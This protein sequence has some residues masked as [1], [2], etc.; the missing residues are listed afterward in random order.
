MKR[1]RG[2]RLTVTTAAFLAVIALFAVACSSDGQPT[3]E[4]AA[5][6]SRDVPRDWQPADI[7]ESQGDALWDT[8]PALLT[9]NSDARL[10]L[11]VFET[12]SGLH[13]AATM[14]IETEDPAAIPQAIQDDAALTP[15]SRLLVRE[16]ALLI[17]DP[18][19]GDSGT[20]FSSSDDPLPGAIRS[21]LVRSFDGEVLLYSDSTTFTVGSVLAVVTVWY[22][23]AEGPQ[24]DI[25]DLVVD[26]ERRL[27]S[28]KP[29][30]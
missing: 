9:A 25:D 22:P 14:F 29:Q 13:G 2:L 4:S 26:V 20:Y 19:A 18:L 10:I 23:E 16:D 1:T 27:R 6:S 21:R 30:A 15:L 12:E 28:L 24:R 3:L 5:L 11:R 7:E 17:P 8:L